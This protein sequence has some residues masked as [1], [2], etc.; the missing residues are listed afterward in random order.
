MMPRF[1]FDACGKLSVP[2]NAELQKSDADTC[3]IAYSSG[4]TGDGRPYYAYTAVPPSKY[5]AFYELSSARKSIVL[6]DFGKIISAGF[7]AAP[8]AEVVREMRDRYGFDENYE[9][10]ISEEIRRQRRQSGEKQ[11]EKRLLNIVAMM[12]GEMRP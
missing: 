11:E 5:R 4:T 12:K 7:E 1:D 3:I 8:P 10:K 2:T 9:H 6:N